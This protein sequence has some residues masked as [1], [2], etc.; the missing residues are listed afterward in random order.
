MRGDEREGEIRRGL[1]FH[2]RKS[3][4]DAKASSVQKKF[5]V[6]VRMP[7]D[8]GKFAQNGDV[9]VR[10]HAAD[11]FP[12]R[13]IKP[14]GL[15][16]RAQFQQRIGRA[17]FFERDHVGIHRLDAFADFGFRLGRFDVQTRFGRLIQII[18]DIVSG[19]AES[20]GWRRK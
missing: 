7:R 6:R 4:A 3:T 8:D 18:F 9:D 14:V 16:R 20:F 13:K 1:D 2:F 12:K 15:E 10:V 11:V 17:H 5:V 19:D